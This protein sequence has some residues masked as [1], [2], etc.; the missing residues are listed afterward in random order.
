M[1]KELLWQQVVAVKERSPLV[2]SITNYVVMNFNANALLAAGASPIM[3]HAAEEMDD[4][5]N[6]SGALVV[7]IGTLDSNWVNSMK[8]AIKAAE[9]KNKPWVLDPV[10]AGA[11]AYRNQVIA[12]LLAI[13]RPAVIRGN[14]SE[15][16]AVA[17]AENKTRGVDS[18]H[19]SNDAIEAAK[20]LSNQLKCV[21][22][23]SGETDYITSNDMVTGLKNGHALMTRI[24]GMG[25]TASALT[26][27]FCAVQADA[28]LATCAA[29]AMMGVAGEVAVKKA[30]GPATLQTAFLDA[31]YTMDVTTFMETVHIV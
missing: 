22:C 14:A 16:L 25:C 28:H 21:V 12:E 15:I 1:T 18:T 13:H 31:L 4:M 7:N 9:A 20:Q 3:A 30:G 6:I 24:T 19:S 8:I 5:V 11:T 23:I 10:G 29:M 2:H 27:A 17:N 26:G